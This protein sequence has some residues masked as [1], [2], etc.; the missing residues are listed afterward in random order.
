MIMDVWVVTIT[1][2][3]GKVL[4]SCVTRTEEEA[5]DR[6][7][8]AIEA[9]MMGAMLQGNP[10]K[11]AAIEALLATTQIRRARLEFLDG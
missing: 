1:D 4:P 2:P 9:S 8:E 3:F 11:L 6:A 7:A 5:Y 10:A